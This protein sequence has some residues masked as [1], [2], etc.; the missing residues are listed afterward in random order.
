MVCCLRLDLHVSIVSFVRRV[1]DVCDIGWVGASVWCGLIVLV[2]FN[3][4]KIKIS[5][6][7]GLVFRVIV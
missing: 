4:F 3:L 1:A 2:Y 7:N 5:G 6:L